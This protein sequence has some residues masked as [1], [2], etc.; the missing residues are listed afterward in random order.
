M[1]QEKASMPPVE[2]PDRSGNHEYHAPLTVQGFR[3]AETEVRSDE[4]FSSNKQKL[5]AAISG[6]AFYVVGR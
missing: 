3:I 2:S 4:I 1:D 6:W 5:Y